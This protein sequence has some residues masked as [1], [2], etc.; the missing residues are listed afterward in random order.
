MIDRRTK[1][2]AS[3]PTGPK[4][5][6]SIPKAF[7]R[8]YDL[9]YNLWWSWDPVGQRPL[10][11]DRPTGVGDHRN[12]IALLQYVDSSNLGG[13]VLQRQL[14]R[15]LRRGRRTLRSLSRQR[16]NVVRYQPPSRARRPGRLS[17]RR[18]RDQRET[19]PLLRRPR[20]VGRRSR[21]GG[22]RPR[23][24]DGRCRPAVPARVLPPGCRS[25]R[26]AAAHLPA[27]RVAASAAARDPRSAQRPSAA[28]LRSPER[29][30]GRDRRMARRCRPNAIDSPRHRPT[31]ERP[32][33]PAD[34]PHPLRAGARGPILPKRSCSESAAPV[35]CGR[36]G[37]NRPCGMSTRATP[38]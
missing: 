23:H 21:E 9:A 26:L 12:P 22:V 11:K 35:C 7:N 33:R 14:H 27:P 13:T 37:S 25:R 3:I 36:S 4:A 20:R 29:S 5:P 15:A 18:V 32:G 16:R 30:R 10:G 8:L 1:L 34:H 31:G 6:L 38:R 19:P 24:A 2:N 28:R 17:V